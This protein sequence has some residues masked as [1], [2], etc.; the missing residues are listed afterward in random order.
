MSKSVFINRDDMVTVNAEGAE[1]AREIYISLFDYLRDVKANV[2]AKRPVDIESA[3][4]LIKTLVDE[5][6]LIQSIF[7]LTL[8]DN[9]EKDYMVT[10]QA[11]V[12]V[13][14]LKLGLGLEYTA[15]QLLDLGVVSLIHDLGIWNIPD[16]IL[17]K[18]SPLMAAELGMV[19]DHSRIGKDILASFERERP[20]LPEVVYQH[21]E[22]GN[23]TGYP[24]GFCMNEMH[25]YATL[26]C[27]V[28]AYEGM[29]H[30]RPIRRAMKWNLT[31]RELI[32][33]FKDSAFPAD[34]IK[35]FLKEITIYPEGCHVLLN[36][37]F[38]CEVVTINRDNPLRPDV[39]V[40]M[41]HSG[42]KVREDKI[43]R[44]IDSPIYN[45]MDCVS[46]DEIKK[47]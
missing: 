32:A 28:D 5:P 34:I 19:R 24:R 27:F 25:D 6:A 12:A 23:G 29:T 38:V 37:K 18:E 20:W 8:K 17:N 22:R 47:A 15:L 35:S 7:P 36:N 40:V 13:C 42:R 11:N 4:L 45:I 21:H 39:R 9:I 3:Y 14:A 30:H 43:I 33:E 10:H 46:L 1:K 16:D 44:L 31:A 41:D 2:V 26:I